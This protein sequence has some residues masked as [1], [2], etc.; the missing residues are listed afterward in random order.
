VSAFLW[1]RTLWQR[2]RRALATVLGVAVGVGAVL[3]TALASRAAVASM[4]D[5]VEAL[6][7]AARIEVTRA[8]G[9]DVAD[10]ARLASVGGELLV[11]P[12][13]EGTALLP[14]RGELVRLLGLDASAPG[15]ALAGSLDEKEIERFFR[16][17]GLVLSRAAAERLALATGDR[18]ELVVQSRRVSLEVLAVFEP[19]RLAAAWERVLVLDVACAQELLGR[20]QHVDRLELTPREGVERD[21]VKWDDGALTA[22]VRALLPEGYRVGPASLRRD[23]GERF[24]RSLTFN[25]TALAGVS[26]L[27]AVVLVATTLA[28]SVVQRRGVI[29]LLRSLGASRA[30]LAAAVLG[31]AALTGLAGGAAGVAL[32]WLGARWIAADVHGSFATLSEDVLLGAVRLEPRWIV[33]G[34]TLGLGS[35]LAAAFLPLSEAW[36]TPPVQHLRA[37]DLEHHPRRLARALACLALCAGAWFT[38]RLPAW[39]GRPIWALV[40]TL[41]LLATLIVLSGPLIDALARAPTGFLGLRLGTPLRL[42]QAALAAARRRAA[43]AASAVGVAVALAVAM[44]TMV[45]SF[46]VNVID[47]TA[48]TMRSDLY[49]RP[50]SNAEGATAGRIAPEAIALVEQVFGRENVDPYHESSATVEGERILL[51]G[52]RFAIAEHEGGVPFLDGRPYGEVFRVALERHGAVANESFARRFGLARGARVR[53]TAAGGTVERELA[54]VYQDFSGHIGRLVLDLDDFFSLAGDEGAESVGVYLPDGAAANTERERLRSA[55]AGRFELEILDGAEVRAQVLRIFERTFAV[56]GALQAISALVAALAVVLVLT[57]LVRERER[58][59]AI[60]R[61]LGGSRAQLGG[62]VAGQAL[63]LG[64]AGALGG[65]GLGLVVG[66]VMV[67]VVNVQSFGWSLRFTLPVSVLLSAG[68]VVPA[69]LLAG[70]IPAWLSSRLQPQEALREPD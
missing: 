62:M 22:R 11:T 46:R 70:W 8:G 36:R 33:A 6:A 19:E 10:M 51:G 29:A 28:T 57:A 55:L 65:L 38:A 66:Y 26:V 58:E 2:P 15:G 1:L 69:C 53:I 18:L 50:L 20:T 12:V 37:L 68:A 45:E 24:V 4:T 5:D 48:Q 60:V 25:L 3:S 30:Q 31:E 47:W 7:G 35:A 16:G 23:E 13:V 9:V 34:I 63:F 40:S 52:A 67:A 39:N 43:W 32:G 59:L 49:L 27:V 41:L 56:T 44:T 17:E 64:L 42:A 21:G 61:V 54:G 14:E